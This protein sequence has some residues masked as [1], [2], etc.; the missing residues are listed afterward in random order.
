MTRLSQP[1]FGPIRKIQ[2]M[3]RTGVGTSSG[4]KTRENQI[5][6]PGRS[7]R[8]ISHASA[9]AIANT[10]MTVP[11]T[12]TKVSGRMRRVDDR[13]GEQRADV[14]ERPVRAG[15]KGKMIGGTAQR[16]KHQHRQRHADQIERRAGADGEHQPR[17]PGSRL[18]AARNQRA[19]PVR[20]AAARPNS[21]SRWAMLSGRSQATCNWPECSFL[22]SSLSEVG[23]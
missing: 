10:S 23:P 4:N 20:I 22:A 21:A 2:A 14:L 17:G 8:S 18:S 1:A 13:I 16:G 9:N 15:L 7:V 12:N 19:C 11:A 3:A 6:R 5:S